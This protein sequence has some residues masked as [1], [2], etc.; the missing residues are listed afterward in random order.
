MLAGA[1]T[2][3]MSLW[4]VPDLATAV[5][6]EEFY[7]KLLPP[8]KLPRDE[9]L[10]AA[11]RYTRDLTVGQLTSDGW[12]SAETI[13]RLAGGREKIKEELQQLAQQ[14]QDHCPFAHPYYWGAFICQGDPRP[15]PD[16]K[17]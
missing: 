14:P 5:L 16:V 10:R 2:L 13:E 6:M 11:Q 3:V 12:L 8:H 4:K 15:L 1:K 7:E 9:A 17:S